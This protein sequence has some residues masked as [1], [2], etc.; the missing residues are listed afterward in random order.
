LSFRLEAGSFLNK[1][2]R[3]S[4][5]VAAAAGCENGEEAERCHDLRVRFYPNLDPKINL[6]LYEAIGGFVKADKT[7]IRGRSSATLP[8][9]KRAVTS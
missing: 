4:I 2:V 1:F 3:C 9:R 8:V 5:R 7:V 6:W